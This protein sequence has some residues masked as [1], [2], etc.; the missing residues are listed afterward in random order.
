[1]VGWAA[2][3]GT[4][5]P[6]YSYQSSRPVGDPALHKVVNFVHCLVCV[7]VVPLF[8][9]C[10]YKFLKAVST[11]S[12]FNHADQGFLTTPL[13]VVIHNEVGINRRRKKPPLL[14]GDTPQL[15][16]EMLRRHGQSYRSVRALVTA[17]LA[18][19]KYSCREL[20]LSTR[21]CETISRL[22]WSASWAVSPSQNSICDCSC[23][24]LAKRTDLGNLRLYLIM[25]NRLPKLNKPVNGWSINKLDSL[26]H[27]YHPLR[28]RVAR[29]RPIT[30][31][32]GGC[33]AR[34]RPR[35]LGW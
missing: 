30:T 25:L 26:S 19:S 31:W 8:E 10:V 17:S 23:A 22:A 1:V 3:R 32:L 7:A 21:C 4:N 24:A 33:A 35:A 2:L 15:V 14:A 20:S 13:T 34:V 29:G 5:R 18:P 11:H 6:A 27:R 12:T 28:V 9:P 16:V